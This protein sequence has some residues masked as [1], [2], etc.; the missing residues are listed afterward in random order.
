MLRIRHLPLELLITI[1]HFIYT[2]DTIPRKSKRDSSHKL[3]NSMLVCQYFNQ[4]IQ[5][6]PALWTDLWLV[7]TPRST[8][9]QEAGW[10]EWIRNHIAKSGELPLRIFFILSTPSLAKVYPI[11][12]P[13]SPRWVHL[14]ITPV[15]LS[16]PCANDPRTLQPLFDAPIP[17]LLSLSVE[18]LGQWVDG[19]S[20]IGTVFRRAP[21]LVQLEWRDRPVVFRPSNEDTGNLQEYIQW[22]SLKG[23]TYDFAQ[24][25]L[26]VL[27]LRG[28][29][30]RIKFECMTMSR[31]RFL[32][33]S[34]F[35]RASSFLEEWQLPAL[36]E[37]H[38]SGNPCEDVTGT[39]PFTLPALKRLEWHDDDSKSF[40]ADSWNDSFL[41]PR[42]LAASPK[43][44]YFLI[45][46]QSPSNFAYVTVRRSQVQPTDRVSLFLA[47][48]KAT[49]APKYCPEL[50]KL[51]LQEASLDELERL[52]EI[53]PLLENVEVVAL[54][55]DGIP[56][57]PL[58]KDLAR[59]EKVKERTEVA[60]HEWV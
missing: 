51:R 56:P 17:R 50:Q 6:A 14:T 7:R 36:E 37:L 13:T 12:L 33:L 39:A 59:L 58:Q 41:L 18:G 26:E 28:A 10:I 46:D 3:L 25:T 34:S 48:D 8:E 30:V 55:R 47:T 27:R 32:S 38:L 52:T 15:S 11:L 40:P 16:S 43:L 23:A 54:R 53:R 29:L 22:A 4:I 42:V 2:D 19:R 9:Q 45:F 35:S 44:R 21:R 57:S 20:G 49:G 5:T 24:D 60:F 31:L 1:F